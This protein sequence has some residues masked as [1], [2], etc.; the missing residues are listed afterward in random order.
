MLVL[1]RK[2]GESIL[3]GAGI[4]VTIKEVRGRQVKL[5]ITAP[6]EVHIIRSELIIREGREVAHATAD[7]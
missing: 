5:A 2:A 6:Q 3:I 1:T 7:R 4:L